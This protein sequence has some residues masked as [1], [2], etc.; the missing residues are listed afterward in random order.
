[1]YRVKGDADHEALFAIQNDHHGGFHPHDMADPT[2]LALVGPAQTDEGPPT[3]APGVQLNRN[4]NTSFASAIKDYL[5]ATFQNQALH[6]R[7]LSSGG[8]M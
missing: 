6:G 5:N 2:E 8:P 7:S 3:Q 4:G 1:M